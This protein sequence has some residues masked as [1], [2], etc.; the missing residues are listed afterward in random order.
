MDQWLIENLVCPRHK[1]ALSR[2]NNLSCPCGCQYPVV[3]GIPI[4]SF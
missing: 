4:Q 2:N 3:D 1:D